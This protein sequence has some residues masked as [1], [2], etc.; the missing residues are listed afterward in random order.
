MTK[1]KPASAE[2]EKRSKNKQEDK[3]KE[4]SAKAIED[5]IKILREKLKEKE[6]E[7]AEYLNTL[8]R[9]QADFDNY[10]KRMVKEQ[11]EFLAVA[12]KDL[13][14]ELIPVI[15]NLERALKASKESKDFN[16]LSKGVEMVHAQLMEVLNRAGLSEIDPNGEEFDPFHHEAVMQVESEKHADNTVVDVLHKG[17]LLKGKL[18]RPAAV[19]VTKKK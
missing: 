10:K 12:S 4:V 17:Y 2:E 18:L 3:D 8:Q 9:L 5:D 19:K 1:K 6:T 16:S 15:D 13:I 11:T 7:A 14:L